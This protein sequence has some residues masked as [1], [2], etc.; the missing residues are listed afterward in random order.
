[1]QKGM[2]EGLTVPLDVVVKA[3]AKASQPRMRAISCTRAFVSRAMAVFE[4]SW[5]S[6]AIRQGC[7]ERCTLGGRVV[8]DMIGRFEDL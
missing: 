7:L 2:R 1:M 6:F 3:V 5:E 4:R 8:V